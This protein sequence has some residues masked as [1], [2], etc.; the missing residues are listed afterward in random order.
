[1]PIS[2][3]VCLMIWIFL[4][5]EPYL[6]QVPRRGGAPFYSSGPL[7]LCVLLRARA[8]LPVSPSF[9]VPRPRPYLESLS[10]CHQSD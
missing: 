6:C 9:C 5:S 10:R 3:A 7:R 4:S 1:M 8:Q 2:A